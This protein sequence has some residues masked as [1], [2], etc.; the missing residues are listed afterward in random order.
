MQC[1]WHESRPGVDV[2]A[3]R[4]SSASWCVR[5]NGGLLH[6]V[7]CSSCRRCCVAT[8]ELSNVAVILQKQLTV[9]SCVCV[10]V[11]VGLCV[12]L[13]ESSGRELH[14]MFTRTY[15]I[16]YQ[17]NSH[18]FSVLFRDLRAYLH[19]S[20]MNLDRVLDSFFSSLLLR[21][22]TLL[23]GQYVFD[24]RYLSCI[25]ERSSELVPFGD[26]PQKL[27]VQVKRALI[28][29]RTFHQGLTVGSHVVSTLS[30]VLALS[31]LTLSCCY[32]ECM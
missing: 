11:C 16:L 24:Q 4:D 25:R 31:L 15:G 6:C 27:N 14:D 9:S 18:V 21:M 13:I 22:F 5:I 29:A 20:E 8:N 19:G 32:V 3:C 23:N 12:E 26:V 28:A 10:C 7:N 2:D 17:Q 30:T 1:D